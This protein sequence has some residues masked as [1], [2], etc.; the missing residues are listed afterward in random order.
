MKISVSLPT[1][2]VEFVDG[3]SARRDISSRSAVIHHAIGLL[4][5]VSLEDAYDAAF[6][7]WD[8]HGDAELWNATSAD[9]VGDAQ[10]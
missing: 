5:M 3:Y 6:K 10:R 1:D 9:G 7:E 2:D 4:K 8:A